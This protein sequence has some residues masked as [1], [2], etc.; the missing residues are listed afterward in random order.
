MDIKQI[1]ILKQNS[2]S[3]EEPMEILDSEKAGQSPNLAKNL[4]MVLEKLAKLQPKVQDLE[5]QSDLE[6][7][8]KVILNCQHLVNEQEIEIKNLEEQNQTLA[9][10]L[11]SKNKTI[12]AFKSLSQDLDYDLKKK[13]NL[14]L[15][16]K[17]HLMKSSIQDLEQVFQI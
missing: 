2:N 12:S 7:C 14:D 3:F 1:E 17:F 16:A 8:K 13:V 6:D 5:V 11:E 10:T 4:A 9:K 15:K